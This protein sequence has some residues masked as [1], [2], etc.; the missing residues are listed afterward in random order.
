MKGLI[1]PGSRLSVRFDIV[2]KAE[3]NPSPAQMQMMLRTLLADRF[4]LVVHDDRRELMVYA[5]VRARTD[6]RIGA[7]MRVAAPCF[8]MPANMPPPNPPP[9]NETACGFRLRPGRIAALGVTMPA[10]ASSLANQVNR[11]VVD[12]TGLDGE[13]D[14][15]VEWTPFQR[16]A[17]QDA[18]ATADDRPVDSG[19]SIF[20]A[21]QEQL[22]LRLD[23]TRGPVDVLLIDR[24]EKPGPD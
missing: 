1:L 22:G 19:P 8:R 4:K 9:P 17:S 14:L 16:P 7:Q 2:A 20:T 12:R 3:G 15:E 13:F 11:V 5:L 23:S 21:V 6:G 10:L 24:A 18:P